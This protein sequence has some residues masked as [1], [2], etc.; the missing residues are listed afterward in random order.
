MK[1]Y[2]KPTSCKD[3]WNV[4]SFTEMFCMKSTYITDFLALHNLNG[5]TIINSL[6]S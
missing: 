5:N 2:K 4:F 6:I 1:L 3:N